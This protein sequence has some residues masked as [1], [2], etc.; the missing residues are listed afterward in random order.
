MSAGAPTRAGGGGRLALPVVLGL[1]GVALVGALLASLAIG[2]TLIPLDRALA[3]LAAPDGSREAVIVADARLPRT[4]I[5]AAVGAALGVAGAVMQA[6]SRNPLAEP[7]ILGISWGAALGAVGAQVTLGIGSPSAAIG[8]A[9]LGAALAGGIVVGIGSIGRGGLSPTRLVVAGAAVSTLLWAI[10]QGLLVLDRQSLE[11][12]RRWL[13]GSLVGRDAD[14]LVHVAPYLGAGLVLALLLA[15]PLTA[16]SLGEDVAR[17]LGQRTGTVKL[18]AALAVVLLA[19]AAVA[20]AGPIVLVGLAV[21]HVAR[22]LVGRDYTRVLPVSAL[23][24]AVLVLASDV[25]AR[26][27]IPPEEIPVGVM[28]ALVGVPVFLHAVRRGVRPL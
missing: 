24:G 18:A 26:R 16:L 10:L 28:T 23:L 17:G 4:L 13:A 27:V 7:G 21:P 1:G 25:V 20:V 11:A 5:A 14:S 22:A 12:S 2:A 6:V 15:R 8:F 3:V 9:L 19:G